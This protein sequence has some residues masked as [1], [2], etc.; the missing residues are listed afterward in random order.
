MASTE[1]S[2]GRPQGP[3][4]ARRVPPAVVTLRRSL[5]WAADT[6]VG[7]SVCAMWIANAVCAARVATRRAFGEESRAVAV[8]NE[9]FKASVAAMLLQMNF[10]FLI[11]AWRDGNRR[12]RHE[13][14]ESGGGGGEAMR[15]AIEGRRPERNGARAYQ[16]GLCCPV[17]MRI[18][19]V[20]RVL[21]VASVVIQM[22][23]PAKGSGAAKLTS[24]LGD[25]GCFFHAVMFCFIIFP[26]YVNQLKRGT[27]KLH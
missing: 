4:P 6:V 25:V 23:G 22:H 15:P 26:N 16:N 10:A 5:A 7:S 27:E 17:A 20:L 14:G 19:W 24:V 12:K 1:A 2:M 21:M 13:V 8:V 18:F 11:L 9:L 3:P